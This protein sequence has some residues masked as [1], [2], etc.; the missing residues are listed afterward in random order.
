MK[1]RN[2]D[3]YLFHNRS[4]NID[5][6]LNNSYQSRGDTDSIWMNTM[7]CIRIEGESHVFDRILTA[8]RQTLKEWC[9]DGEN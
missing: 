7:I 2:T 1:V 8:L 9:S 6:L 5:I 3:R 4:S